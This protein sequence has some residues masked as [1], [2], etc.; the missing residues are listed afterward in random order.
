MT[1]H[2]QQFSNSKHIG[3]VGCSAEGAALCYKTICTESSNLMGLH[4][5]PEVSI[6]THS[7]ID[8]VKH[9][10]NRNMQGVGDIILSSSRKLA[11][12]GADF[13]I[14]PD[15]TIHQAFDYV[16]EQSPLPWLHIAEEV[17]KSAKLRGFKKLGILGTQWL[18]ESDVY[19]NKIEAAGLDWQRPINKVRAELGKIIMHE[20]VYG[21][22]MP[23]SIVYFQKAISDLKSKG[24]DAVILGCTEIPLI[25]N[26]SNSCLP[27]LD[28]NRLLADAAMNYAI[29]S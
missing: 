19:P 24:C 20:L 22:F 4:A 13:L 1:T 8:Y 14:C 12:I 10:D 23:E 29:Y 5:H 2:K 6:H 7:M 17:V 26:N 16:A 25:I 9:L 21:R 18:T 28:S 27:T 3:I 15:N 11:A